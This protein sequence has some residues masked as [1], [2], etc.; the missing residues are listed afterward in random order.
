MENIWKH[1]KSI[2]DFS[3]KTFIT[4]KVLRIIYWIQAVL[5]GVLVGI[6][7]YY[8]FQESVILGILA[9]IIAPMVF[10]IYAVILRVILE[11]IVVIFRIAEYAKEISELWKT[12]STETEKGAKKILEVE[13]INEKEED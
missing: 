6:F 8:G 5:G 7:I 11:I 9:I 12:I 3:F 2:F 13:E 4:I 10:L 1:I